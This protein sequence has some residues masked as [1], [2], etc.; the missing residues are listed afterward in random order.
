MWPSRRLLRIVLAL[1]I[2]LVAVFI[3]QGTAPILGLV[4]VAVLA[5]LLVAHPDTR[6]VP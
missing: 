6:D 5:A 1:N 2:A 3:V 4:A